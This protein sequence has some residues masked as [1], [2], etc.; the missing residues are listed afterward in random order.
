M[1]RSACDWYSTLDT[2]ACNNF[3]VLKTA[4]SKLFTSLVAVIGTE[5]V[6]GMQSLPFQSSLL[7]PLV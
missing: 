4:T 2:V 1:L 5:A 7:S 3:E 6:A